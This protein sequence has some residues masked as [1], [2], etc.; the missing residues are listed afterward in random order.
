MMSM[1]ALSNRNQLLARV[2]ASPAVPTPHGGASL[3]RKSEQ[4]SQSS[5]HYSRPAAITN[6]TSALAYD[7][8]CIRPALDC[9]A[10]HDL[11]QVVIIHPSNGLGDLPGA[12]ELVNGVFEVRAGLHR[13]RCRPQSSSA[14]RF[15][16]G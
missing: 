2:T 4:E 8:S 13:Q 14:S 11:C 16:A 10:P 15:T 5:F 3:F 9:G 7:D 6:D 12:V 1:E